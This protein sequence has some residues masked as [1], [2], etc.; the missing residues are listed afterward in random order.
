MAVGNNNYVKFGAAI[1]VVR[2]RWLSGLHR[3][4]GEQ[5]LL[6]HYQRATRDGEQRLRQ[7]PAGR[8]QRAAR[9]YQT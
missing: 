3:R 6:R 2:S 9:I 5:E 8:G 7:A 4:A 1:V